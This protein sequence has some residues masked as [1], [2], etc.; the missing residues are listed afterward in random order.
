MFLRC[1]PLLYFLLTHLVGTNQTSG[2]LLHLGC[3]EI[4]NRGSK[5]GKFVKGGEKHGPRSQYNDGSCGLLLRIENTFSTKA[6]F[7]TS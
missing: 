1:G 5:S 3:L 4:L 2:N 7:K 6:L